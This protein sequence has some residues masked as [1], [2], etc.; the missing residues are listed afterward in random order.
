[1]R[2]GDAAIVT[3]A[4]DVLLQARTKSDLQTLLVIAPTW[5]EERDAIW[6]VP[7]C[8]YIQREEGRGRVILRV[9]QLKE[10]RAESYLGMNMEATGINGMRSVDRAKK[11]WKEGCMLIG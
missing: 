11:G 6:S 1:M 10:G 8:V 2:C 9:E 5:Q 3:V 7:K 4:D